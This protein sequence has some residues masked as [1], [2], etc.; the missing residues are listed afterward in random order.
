MMPFVRSKP[1]LQSPAGFE[2]ASIVTPRFAV[3]DLY[4]SQ[5]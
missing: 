5:L 1:A 2:L 4:I 3:Y